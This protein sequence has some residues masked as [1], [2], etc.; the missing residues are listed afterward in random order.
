MV[1]QE[2]DKLAYRLNGFPLTETARCTGRVHRTLVLAEAMGWVWWFDTTLAEV[3][4]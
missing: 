3:L 4:W 2:L 1:V